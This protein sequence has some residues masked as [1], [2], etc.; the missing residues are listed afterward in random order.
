M[1][2]LFV[3]LAAIYLGAFGPRFRWKGAALLLAAMVGAGIVAT[4]GAA[5]DAQ[6]MGLSF[7]ITPSSVLLALGEQALFAFSFYGLA[8]LARWA[9]LGLTRDDTDRHGVHHP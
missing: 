8:A 1:A 4:I 9:H 5:R 2:A 6:A 7:G 3:A